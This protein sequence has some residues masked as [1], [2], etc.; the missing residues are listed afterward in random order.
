LTKKFSESFKKFEVNFVKFQ[1]NLSP[2]SFLLDKLVSREKLHTLI[3]NLYPGN[4]G[5]SLSYFRSTVSSSSSASTS[6][7]RNHS[8]ENFHETP[9]FLYDNSYLLDA[10]DSEELPPLIID[11]CKVHCPHLFYGE[12]KKPFEGCSRLKSGTFFSPFFRR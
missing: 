8:N 10:L 2:S 3:I 1:L 4:K 12:S 9:S 5:Y 11:F 6:N 7:H